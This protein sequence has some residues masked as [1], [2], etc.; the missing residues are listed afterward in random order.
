MQE[1][2]NKASSEM[3]PQSTLKLSIVTRLFFFFVTGCSLGIGLVLEKCPGNNE[4]AT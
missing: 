1:P 2:G 3:T 4:L